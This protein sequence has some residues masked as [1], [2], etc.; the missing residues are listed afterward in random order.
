MS[1]VNERVLQNTQRITMLESEINQVKLDCG[2]LMVTVEHESKSQTE[3]YQ[4]IATQT[5]E[6]KDLIKERMRQDEE[7]EREHREYR[8]KREMAERAAQLNRE[9]WLRSVLTPQTIVIII[10]MILSLFGLRMADVAGLTSNG[11]SA[12]EAKENP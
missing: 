11:G 9:Q 4:N 1:D 7:R 6:L 3:R 5:L 12:T 8:E 10:A 2:K